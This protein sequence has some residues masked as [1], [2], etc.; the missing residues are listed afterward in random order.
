MLEYRDGVFERAATRGDGEIGEDVTHSARMIK[1]LP[2]KLKY[3]VDLICVGVWMGFAEFAELN[4][5][6]QQAGRE[7][8]CESTECGRWLTS[9]TRCQ[10][11]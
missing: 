10:Y 3:P 6:E 1:T 11:Y 9:A 2:V 4:Q 7:P 5:F 8:F